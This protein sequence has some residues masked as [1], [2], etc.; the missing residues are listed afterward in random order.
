MLTR[1]LL[2]APILA[3]TFV[4][5]AARAEAPKPGFYAAS[6]GQIEWGATK[7][8]ALRACDRAIKADRAFN[9]RAC[10]CT[11]RGEVVELTADTK[12]AFYMAGYYHV[13]ATPKLAVAACE[14]EKKAYFRRNPKAREDD[15]QCQTRLVRVYGPYVRK[16]KGEYDDESYN[17]LSEEGQW[18]DERGEGPC[19]VAGT[20]VMTPSGPKAIER[21][22]VGDAI[23]SWSP[24]DGEVVARVVAVKPR[25][26]AVMTLTL[27][28][29][30]SVT[31]TPNHPLWSPSRNAW[32]P[33]GEI[34][35]GE[36]LAVRVGAGLVPM[37]VVSIA[38]VSPTSDTGTA[39]YDLS[40]EP[41]HSY[42]AAGIWAHNY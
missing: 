42:F 17:Y 16:H 6:C 11:K 37:A 26:A 13:G 31:V 10:N 39:V 2:I 15:W 38:P 4:G 7:K 32:T 19:F 29:G 21:F 41:T 27:A 18:L 14:R 30:R 12:P 33:A 8:A 25:V 28:D 22:E 40:V 23:V 34:A 35:L 24:T 9:Q 20:M 36:T 1:L 5:M 3:F